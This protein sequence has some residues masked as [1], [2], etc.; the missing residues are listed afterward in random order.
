MVHPPMLNHSTQRFLSRP[1][2]TLVARKQVLE[3]PAPLWSV[4]AHTGKAG[5]D[6]RGSIR[7][8]L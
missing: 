5:S 1:S 4:T 7:A 8:A 3:R 6:V 2:L